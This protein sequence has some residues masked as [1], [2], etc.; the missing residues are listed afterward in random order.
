MAS[1]DP[2]KYS[3]MAQSSTARLAAVAGVIAFLWLAISWAVLLP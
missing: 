1:D 3:V 2:F